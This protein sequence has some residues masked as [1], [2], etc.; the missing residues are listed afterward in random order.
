VR[1][2]LLDADHPIDVFDVVEITKTLARVRTPY[3]FE[4]GEELVVRIE[5]DGKLE[6]TRARVRGHTGSADDK[7]TELELESR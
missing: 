2:L 5:R 1:V 7:V 3:L 6:D 4:V